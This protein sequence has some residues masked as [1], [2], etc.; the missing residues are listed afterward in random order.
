MSHSNISVQRVCAGNVYSHNVCSQNVYS[1]NV[2]CVL[3]STP[4]TSTLEDKI[5]MEKIPNEY[6]LALYKVNIYMRFL[7]VICIFTRRRSMSFKIGNFRIPPT[8]RICISL[9]FSLI[10]VG[11]A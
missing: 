10:M 11:F 3:M 7:R 9:I 2:Y 1:H 8:V 5:S 4:N 6:L